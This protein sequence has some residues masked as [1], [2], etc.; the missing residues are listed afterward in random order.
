VPGIPD[1]I[2]SLFKKVQTSESFGAVSFYGKNEIQD[3]DDQ[4][5]E[6]CRPQSSRQKEEEENCLDT[7]A[8]PALFRTKHL[9]TGYLLFAACGQ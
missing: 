4:E 6:A 1:F 3:Y 9:R 5:G 7:A 8:A 2:G